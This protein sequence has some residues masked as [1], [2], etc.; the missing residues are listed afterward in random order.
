MK[1]LSLIFLILP[2]ALFAQLSPGELTKAHEKLE[3]LSNCTQCHVLGEK[4]SNQ[5]CLDCHKEINGL[6]D[7][8]KGYHSS[9]EVK[10][11]NCFACH[12]EHHGRNFQLTRFDQDKFDHQLTGYILEGKHSTIKCA[13]C[14]KPKFIQNKVSQK[15]SDSFLGLGTECLSC[16]EDYHQK[17]LST[18]CSTCHGQDSFVPTVKFDHQKTKFHL[19]GK[20]QKVACAEC[21]KTEERNGKKF[22]KFA[23]VAFQNCTACHKD[24]H[25]NK[26]GQDCMKCHNE[27]SFHQVAGLDNF[28]HDRTSFPLEGKHENLDCRKCHKQS[29]TT[30]VA[31]TRCTDCHDDY[32]KGQFSKMEKKTDCVDCHSVN[33]FKTFSYTIEQHNGGTFKLAGAHMAT[34]CFM[35]HQ[36]NERWEFRTI[37]EKCV[38]CH[39]NIHQGIISEKYMPG[40]QC[41]SCHTTGNWNKVSFDHNQTNFILNGKHSGATCRDCHFKTDDQRTYTQK[42][43]G[44]ATQCETCHTDHHRQQFSNNGKIDCEHCH[45][46][47][48]W[49]AERFD[50]DESR[51]KLEGAHKSTQCV[52]CHKPDIDSQGTFTRYKTNKEIKC[53]NCHS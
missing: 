51:F 45:G 35:C 20:H 29:Y 38:D 30:P 31:H 7:A 14:H 47:E 19:R 23:G 18:D 5:K 3:G 6:I 36:K 41:E 48:N 33:S 44:L 37:G 40:Q 50:H 26:F 46:F 24:V 43:A 13:D 52:K 1:Y 9:V 27:Q 25:E 28:N 22:Q 53:A 34:P 4:V 2:I 42:F 39:E 49:N 17:T 8:T 16:H 10:G 12:S 32:H 15:K 21:H 11:K